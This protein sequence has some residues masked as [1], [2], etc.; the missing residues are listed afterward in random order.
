MSSYRK[1]AAG[2]VSA[3]K[4][5]CFSVSPPYFCLTFCRPYDL[6]A[7]SCCDLCL[8]EY[9]RRI[10][11][12]CTHL[13]LFTRSSA[14]HSTSPMQINPDLPPCRRRL[15]I[16]CDGETCT[17]KHFCGSISDRHRSITSGFKWD[18]IIFY[19]LPFFW[20][21]NACEPASIQT[22]LLFLSA[23]RRE[24]SKVSSVKNPPGDMFPWA[25]ASSLL[26]FLH[27]PQAQQI[28]RLDVSLPAIRHL[29]KQHEI[30]HFIFLS[31]TKIQ[32]SEIKPP[33]FLSYLPLNQ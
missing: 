25:C 10:C 28:P 17:C 15:L 5:S 11:F 9:A 30:V 14:W 24:H 29:E 33:S 1:M 7:S 32:T 22:F 16:R 20:T 23:T 6:F 3:I 18:R 19:L 26:S 4:I 2:R 21:G 27:S 12:W 13:Y 31:K 8:S